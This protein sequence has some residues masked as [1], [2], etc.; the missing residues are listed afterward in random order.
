VLD[1]CNIITLYLYILAMQNVKSIQIYREQLGL[2]QA[3]L[4]DRLG[5]TR[6][7]IAAWEKEE[8]EPSVAQL[9]RIAQALN[10]G[11]DL[12]IHQPQDSLAIV[13]T[14][15]LFRADQ[16]SAL[17]PYLR[18]ALSQKA[19]NYGFIEQLVKEIPTLP[20]MR[21]LK[22]YDPDFVE[23]V[24]RE[25]RD[26]L[27]VG[28]ISPL[29]D[30]FA[31]LE[32]KGLKVILHPLPSEVSGFSAYNEESG[33]TIFVNATHC[34]ERKFFTAL[35]EL[36][37]LIFHRLEYRVPRVHGKGSDHR[38]LTANHLAGAVMLPADVIKR[39]LSAYRDRWI[40]EPL[41]I[42]IKKRYTVSMRTVLYR[43][44]QTGLISKKQ[45][46][47]QIGTLNKKYGKD[48]EPFHL[49]E[50]EHL[51]RLER[52]VYQALIK[53]EITTS[54]ASEI[55]GKPFIE[56]RESLTKWLEEVES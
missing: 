53:E 4:G 11:I 55:L 51:N 54:R 49:P 3:E 56:V 47:Q 36:A 37:H 27:G 44:S 10:I 40:P 45:Q 29:G 42:D 39:E 22:E 43:A 8:R 28:E 46:G 13:E 15:L 2:S 5:V 30:V 6:Q 7:T 21:P 48:D 19:S 12:L 24:A 32:S 18:A 17:T 9:M 16:P 41:L 1:L 34:S 25:I 50:P 23:E 31:I 33:A 35:H 20:E 26:W 14:G 52:L 38:E